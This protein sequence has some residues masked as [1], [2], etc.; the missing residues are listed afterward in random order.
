MI[1]HKIVTEQ[2]VLKSFRLHSKIDSFYCLLND[3]Y[4]VASFPTRLPLIGGKSGL[5]DIEYTSG[6]NKALIVICKEWIL[7]SLFI[8]YLIKSYS[9]IPLLARID[10]SL[11]PITCEAINENSELSIAV[12]FYHDVALSLDA[13]SSLAKSSTTLSSNMNMSNC[14]TFFKSLAPSSLMGILHSEHTQMDN[15][16]IEPHSLS[17]QF[18]SKSLAVVNVKGNASK[19]RDIVNIQ[20]IRARSL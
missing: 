17:I 9:S 12:Q 20:I 4:T 11:L 3:G 16:S 15:L 13:F 2:S 5:F 18:D 10:P 1:I 14:L 7:H 19:K 6:Q 8:S